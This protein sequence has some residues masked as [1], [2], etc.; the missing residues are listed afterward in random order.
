[1]AL[2]AFGQAFRDARAAGDKTFTFNGKSYT[3][4]LAPSASPY[5]PKALDAATEEAGNNLAAYKNMLDAANQNPGISQ[6]AK[7]ALAAN[8]GRSQAAMN[9]NPE[10]NEALSRNYVSR[11]PVSSDDGMKRGGKVKKMAKGGMTRSSASKRADGIATKG[12][13]KGRFM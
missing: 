7:N 9:A 6:V 3:T 11:A 4:D 5:R 13:T 8:I 10:G 1:M 2:S 12:H